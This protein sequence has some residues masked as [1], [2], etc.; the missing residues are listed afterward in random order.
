MPAFSARLAYRR[1]VSSPGP[2]IYAVSFATGY[3]LYHSNLLAPP[4]HHLLLTVR[5]SAVWPSPLVVAPLGSVLCVLLWLLSLAADPGTSPQ[6]GGG[7][8]DGDWEWW[9]LY[10]RAFPPP[11]P[12]ATPTAA[13]AGAAAMFPRTR[14]QS[15]GCRLAPGRRPAR[16]RHCPLRACCGCVAARDHCCF[17]TG[18]CVGYRSLRLFLAFVAAHLALF[19]YGLRAACLAGHRA[20]ELQGLL[21]LHVYD[22]RTRRRSAP[23]RARPLD[24]AA[25]VARAA[26]QAALMALMCA[27]LAIVAFAFLARHARLVSLGMTSGEAAARGKG[28]EVEQWGRGFSLNWEEALFP[29]R[30]LEQRAAGAA[31]RRRGRG[32]GGG[33]AGGAAA[34]IER[35]A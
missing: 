11:T 26:P 29:R 32:G 15:D 27:A 28:V 30:A 5:P 34:A 7:G 18:G 19:V 23:L 20:V 10:E 16:A 12:K 4:Y 6:C 8:Q 14:Q 25:E 31:T 21:D 13:A 33:G 3:W 22:P 1:F 35:R 24:L 9:S 2:L 17:W